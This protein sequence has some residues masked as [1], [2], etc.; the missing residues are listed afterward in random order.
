[1]VEN[2]EILGALIFLFIGIF[3]IFNA[4]GIVKNKLLKKIKN[5]NKAVYVVKVVGYLAT[6]AS[7]FALYFL[8]K[9]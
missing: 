2:L 7:L 8:L 1:M 4:R 9:K 3:F 6:I 5:E